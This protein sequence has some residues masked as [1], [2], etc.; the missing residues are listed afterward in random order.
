MPPGY[1]VIISSLLLHH[2]QDAQIVT[3]LRCAAMAAG[4]MVRCEIVASQDY[5]LIGAPANATN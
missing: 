3:F 1:D 5:D 2:L 4:E